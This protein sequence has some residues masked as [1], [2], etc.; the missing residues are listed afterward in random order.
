MVVG[1]VGHTGGTIPVM[2]ILG[3]PC[4]GPLDREQLLQLLLPLQNKEGLIFSRFSR[5]LPSCD[6]ERVLV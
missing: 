6:V 3:N 1:P 2:H 5:L 4:K